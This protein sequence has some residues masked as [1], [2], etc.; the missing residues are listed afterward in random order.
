MTSTTCS[1][2]KEKQNHVFS[3]FLKQLRKEN[4]LS[5]EQLC[6]HLRQHSGLFYNLDTI[7]VSRWERGVNIPSLAKQAE[8]AELYDKELMS[9]YSAD[10]LFLNE[11]SAL[12]SIPK[13]Q[14][15]RSNHPYY[16]NDEYVIKTIDI[17]D[18]NFY[19]V[20]KMII[21]YEKNP[22]LILMPPFDSF[23]WLQN[24]KISIA[25]AFNGQI[26]G[27]A[28]YLEMSS[29]KIFEFVNIKSDLKVLFSQLPSK[30]PDGMLVLSS[31]GATIELE[32]SIM[33]SYINQFANNKELRYL[34]FSVCDDI[35]I[36]KLKT[37]KLEAFKVRNIA[38][39]DQK[40]S[41]HSFLLSRTELMANRFLLKLA[42][43][44][45]NHLANF[46]TK[47]NNG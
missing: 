35:F 5:Q 23:H 16:S 28:L 19:L 13:D 47:K 3:M 32:N 15:T 7:T 9:I 21:C 43:I 36:K 22:I 29:Q 11:C 10:S 39:R 12:V 42:V 25:T 30:T 20:L 1:Y 33:S 26:V 40:V 38:L 24:L 45:P 34:C 4:D 8:I 31:A 2:S 44:S 17:N 37:V 41:I 6:I 46:I 14:S 18:N 27:H